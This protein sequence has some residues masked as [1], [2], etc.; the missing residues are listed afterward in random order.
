M[1]Q[2]A[3]EGSARLPARCCVPEHPPPPL[4]LCAAHRGAIKTIEAGEEEHRLVHR[5]INHVIKREGLM[6]VVSARVR[7]QQVRGLATAPLR[8]CAGAPPLATHIQLQAWHG[9][10]LHRSCAAHALWRAAG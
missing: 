10:A 3:G 7:R 6:V 8:A 1:R 2:Q 5:V 9:R 4:A